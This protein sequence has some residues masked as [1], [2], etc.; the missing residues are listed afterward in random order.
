MF[1]LDSSSAWQSARRMVS[2][3]RDTLIAIAGVFFLLPELIGAIAL[4]TPQLTK[5]MDQQAMADAI[6]HFY[7]TAGPLLIVLT[8]PMLVGY[9]TL[10][11]MLLDRD[12]PTVARAIVAGMRLL[13]G[14]LAT[15]LLISFALSV[16]WAIAL[17]ILALVMPQIL[18]V[19]VSIVAMIYPLIRVLLIGPEMVAQRV[20]NPVRA[21]AEGLSRTRGHV[22]GLLLYFGPALALFMVVY[23]LIVI[24]IGAAVSPIPQIEIQRMIAEAVSAILLAAGYTY[25]T[26]MVVSAYDQLGPVGGADTTV[27][28]FAQ[29]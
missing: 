3:N 4:P 15:Q 8:L 24:V 7:Q 22:L 17:S 1:T 2:A 13:P 16:V 28:P 29:P 21:I 25:Y 9:L 20:R 14:Y 27:N 26:A 11:G 19:L 18:A 10:L 12:R 6:L 5:G 23:G